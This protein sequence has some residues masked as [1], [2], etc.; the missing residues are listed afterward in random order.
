MDNEALFSR[1]RIG[2]FHHK[3]TRCDDSLNTITYKT[4]LIERYTPYGVTTCYLPDHDVELFL[5]AIFFTEPTVERKYNEKVEQNQKSNRDLRSS[6]IWI[7]RISYWIL[8][9]NAQPFFN[10][11]E[12]FWFLPW[13]K[14][15]R[16]WITSYV[17]PYLTCSSAW[18]SCPVCFSIAPNSTL[19]IPFLVSFS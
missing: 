10:L 3:M 4:T 15:E 11:R 16:C 14:R 19:T 7:M 1:S 18:L 2:S 5:R 6:I 8:I 13:T 12:E 9:R 17:C